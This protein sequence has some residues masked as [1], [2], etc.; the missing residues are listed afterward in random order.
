VSSTP[1]RAVPQLSP[2]DEFAGLPPAIRERLAAEGVLTLDD[3]RAL[4]RQRR[5][6]IFGITKRVADQLSALAGMRP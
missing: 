3:W 5:R 6:S 2:A 1:R 4:S